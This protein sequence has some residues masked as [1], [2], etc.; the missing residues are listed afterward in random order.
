MSTRSAIGIVN[1][2]KTITVIYA[3]WDGYPE[4][5][6]QILV[7][8][9]KTEDKVRQLMDLGDL[10]V[11]GDEI[12]SKVDFDSFTSKDNNQCCAYGRDRG[13]EGVSALVLNNLAE[14]WE[15]YSW[16]SY[17]YLF[18]NGKWNYYKS[19]NGRAMSLKKF[20]R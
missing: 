4:H 10:S 8:S 16:C 19:V 18:K 7:N 9:Y 12:G 14:V 3:H 1:A 2:D 11:L 13:E 17:V 5:N 20:Q 6:G 15:Q